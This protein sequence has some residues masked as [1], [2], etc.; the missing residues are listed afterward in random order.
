VADWQTEARNAARRVGVDP[1]LFVELV[2]Q[3]SHGNPNALSPKG[4]MGY[5]QLMPATARG[6]GVDPSN[7]AQNLLGGAK[8]LKQQLDAFGGDPRKALAAYNAGPGN[9]QK[10]GGVPPFAETQAYVRAILGSLKAG[11]KPG[12]APAIAAPRGIPAPA[13]PA[14]QAAATALAGF[15]PGEASGAG[16][17]LQL[18]S[19]RRQAPQGG[20]LAPPSF[21][22][23]PQIS[24]AYRALSSGGGPAPRQGVGAALSQALTQGGSVT[25]PGQA[26]AD[27]AAQAS[28]LVA[29][30]SS[31]ATHGPSKA[32][33]GAQA[34]LGWARSKIGFKETG[35]N[36]GGLASYLN[37]R[38]G[39][40][41]QPWCAMFTSAAVTKGGA[42]TSARTAS[43]AEVRR[44]AEQGSGGYQR[45]F[46]SAKQ[47]KAGDLILF[48]N[49]H[50]GMVQ[51]VSHGRINYVGGNQSNGVTE[52][53]V[54]VGHGDI[55]RPRY[56]ARK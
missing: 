14:A 39:M 52:A 12:H 37:Q 51:S 31:G 26:A 48:G 24:D 43:V 10:Y 36:S 41:N 13:A 42:P 28:P 6:L 21:A 45:G 50:I 19:A 38:F 44:Q 54:P 15:D 2:R 30:A 18:A 32:P 23:G 3:E 17:L 4:A 22:A 53:S 33:E 29:A 9:V 47:A 11:A 25:T 35:T 27:V 55:V 7:P 5:T 8:Y 56:G 49:D 34:A 20:G 40:S 16:S 1:N 46:V